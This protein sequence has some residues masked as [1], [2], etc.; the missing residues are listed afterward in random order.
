MK[1][2]LWRAA[3]PPPF[4]AAPAPAPNK[5]KEDKQHVKVIKTYEGTTGNYILINKKMLIKFYHLQV[6]MVAM[7]PMKRWSSAK[8][9]LEVLESSLQVQVR[10]SPAKK[11]APA[12]KIKL[13][14]R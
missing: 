10:S 2:H 11:G 8:P 5:I 7:K 1:I 3:P 13:D 4:L 12:Q 9:L 14:V 6:L